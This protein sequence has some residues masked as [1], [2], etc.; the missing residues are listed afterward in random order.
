[1]QKLLTWMIYST[2]FKKW[3]G[4]VGGFCLGMLA[5]ARYW[6][7]IRATLEVWGVSR[8]TWIGALVAVVGVCGIGA[9]VGLSAA[10]AVRQK[11]EDDE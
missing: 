1:M 5:S 11:H 2:Q 9:S 10:K 6:R 7:Q 8:E 3:N 4:I